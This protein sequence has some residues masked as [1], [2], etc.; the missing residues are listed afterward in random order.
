MKS[1]LLL[2]LAGLLF[3][4]AGDSSEDGED[5]IVDLYS[6]D[7]A[8]VHMDH[9][10]FERLL[11]GQHH[12]WAVEFY[13][14]WCGHCQLYAPT[15]LRIAQQTA[16]WGSVLK[17]GAINCAR[18]QNLAICRNY[19]VGGY[20]WVKLFAPLA[21]EGDM[22]E[23]VSHKLQ[24][25]MLELLVN[26]VTDLQARTHPPGWPNLAPFSGSLS[27]FLS[28]PEPLHALVVEGSANSSVGRQV[29]LDLSVH[30]QRLLVARTV[31]PPLGLR[32]TETARP[33]LVTFRDGQPQTELVSRD[34]LP[35]RKLFTD[36][37]RRALGVT[38][39][40]QPPD[41]PRTA[42]TDGQ[43]PAAAAEP[44]R[45][46]AVSAGD[47]VY[48]VDLENAVGY[49]LRQEVAG[50]K[51]ISGEAL[52]A[53]RN[54]VEMLIKYLPVR[55]SVIEAV[56]ELKMFLKGKKRVGGAEIQR[57]LEKARSPLPPHRP[58]HGCRG[59]QPGLRGYTCGLWSVFHAAT[60][61][62]HQL[63]ESNNVSI[64][65]AI[66]GYVKHF[67]SCAHC[68]QH[69]QEMSAREGL[70]NV[71]H[72]NEAMIW[73]WRAHNIVNKRLAGDG[74]EDPQHP[75]VQFP[76]QTQCLA[77]FSGDTY[78]E[79]IIISFLHSFYGKE[80]MKLDSLTEDEAAAAAA[81]GGLRPAAAL[82]AAGARN[83][84]ELVSR[85]LGRSGSSEGA[86][87]SGLLSGSDISLCVLLWVFSFVTLVLAF[88]LFKMKKTY[89][90]KHSKDYRSF[91][92]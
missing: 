36:A 1:S 12:V 46:T 5:D 33:L 58:W 35:P 43:A 73:L 62:A 26:H 84:V 88:F 76:T 67:F 30:R 81:A 79:P 24:E 7:S 60:V 85:V 74:T 92:K 3:V 83:R 9:S 37:L 68:S 18:S 10:N 50:K 47:A 23:K 53:L 56:S 72:T 8:V 14:S 63:E 13:N 65:P 11:H 39:S 22:G 91:F 80:A 49:A 28:S 34:G 44:G 17:V 29:A 78:F 4:S 32:P 89:K 38:D 45:G 66:H 20:P 31:L 55:K 86:A 19:D 77:C 27:E 51:D 82:P 69:F 90:R 21:K 70:F 16:N 40:E 41:G 71:T 61:Q 75:K 59:S 2:L 42:R 54:F 15:W 48:M 25:E 52:S 64:L 57:H 6:K 87:A